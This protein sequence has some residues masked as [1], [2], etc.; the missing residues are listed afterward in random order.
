MVIARRQRKNLVQVLALHPQ[1]IFARCVAR[2]FPHLKH[3][4]Y[5]DFDLNGRGWRG[6]GSSGLGKQR[7][8][9]AAEKYER[10]IQE[11]EKLIQGSTPSSGIKVYITAEQGGP[12]L[13]IVFCN[14]YDPDPCG[15]GFC[16]VDFSLRGLNLT[17]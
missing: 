9:A 15:T 7:D 3:G 13:R 4:D 16:S 1:L 2:I 10:S 6:N 5:D 14:P 8:R 12:Q 11:L 17:R